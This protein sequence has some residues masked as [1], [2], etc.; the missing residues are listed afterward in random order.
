MQYMMMFQ[1]TEPDFAKRTDPARAA[2]YWGGWSAFIGAMREAGI[3]V[4]GDGLQGP[5]LAT[6]VRIRDGQRTVQDGPYADTKEQLA[7][8]VVIEVE[9]LDMALEWAVKAPCASSGSV[10]VRPVLL[11][12][13]RP[14]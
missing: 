10:E 8:Y 2:E 9:D 6:T 5:E 12:P 3:V 13:A 11:V 7:G 14:A 1:E 4:N